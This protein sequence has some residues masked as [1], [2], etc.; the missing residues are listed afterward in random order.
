[1]PGYVTLLLC[2]ALGWTAGRVLAWVLRRRDK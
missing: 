2:L 1:M